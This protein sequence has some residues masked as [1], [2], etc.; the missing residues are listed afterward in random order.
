MTAHAEAARQRALDT[1]RVV[2]SL[3]EAAYDDIVRLASLLCEAPIALISL[4]DRDRQWLK[5]R[6]GFDLA[7]TP[8]DVAFCDH[9]IRAPDSL[10]EIADATRDARFEQNPL[11]TQAE[12]VRFYAGMPL[13][14]PSG[15][16]IGTVCVLDRQPR[17]LSEGQRAGLASLA[18]L[19]MNLLEA[20]H[21]ERELER[22]A[23]F[24]AMPEPPPAAAPVAAEGFTVAVFEV[25][26]Y[27]GA[28]ERSGERAIERALSQFEHALEACLQS[29]RGDSI[30]RSTGSPE[31]IVVLRGDHVDDSLRALEEAAAAFEARTNLQV[32]GAS[33]AALEPG[34]SPDAVFLRADSGL[35]EA[36]DARAGVNAPATGL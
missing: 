10:F 14:T 29:G 31:A 19:T 15:A 28:V 3:P 18:R 20:R 32:L 21:R 34:E 17:E 4:I 1:Y 24:D 26:D 2:D 12:G 30:S 33:A 27:A 9:A 8:R 6:T 25:Q 11:V 16:A 22:A 36:K 23:R 13:V 7:Q 35:S 5:A